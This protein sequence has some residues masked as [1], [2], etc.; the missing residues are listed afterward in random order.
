MST[1]YDSPL[2]TQRQP[3]LMIC[4]RGFQDA[5]ALLHGT[6]QRLA[7]RRSNVS[8]FGGNLYPET[9]GSIAVVD[10]NGALAD[11]VGD[12]IR[13]T[14]LGPGEAPHV[15]VWVDGS[16]SLEPDIELALARRAFLELSL[17]SAESLSCKIEVIG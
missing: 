4:R 17:L 13:V 2:L 16:V 10:P 3:M 14:L 15:Y 1:I 12:I 8:W 9:A 6:A 7:S 11:L 5:Q